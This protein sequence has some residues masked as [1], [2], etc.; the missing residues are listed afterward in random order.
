MIA[1][2]RIVSI[3][4]MAVVIPM[5]WLAGK[6]H[7]LAHHNWSEQS[8]GR[9]IDLMYD[10]FSE[11]ESNGE[12]MLDEDFIMRIFSPLYGEPPE[13]EEYLEE[14]HHCRGKIYL[15]DL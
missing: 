4:F 13:F 5:H 3:V 10:A 2:L 14:E 11:V 6:T 9:A 12:L 7:E 15:L 8:M 1:Q